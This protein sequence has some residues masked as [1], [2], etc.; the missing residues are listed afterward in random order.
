MPDKNK[1]GEHIP[2]AIAINYFP[3]FRLLLI[4]VAITLQCLKHR[5]FKT[6][7]TLLF[8]CM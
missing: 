5:A 1:A 2:G 6:Q 8:N 7:P 4:K 3:V